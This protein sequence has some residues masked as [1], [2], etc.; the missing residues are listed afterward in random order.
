M[1]RSL[2]SLIFLSTPVFADV[3]KVVTDIAPVH[4]LVAMVMEGIETP[5]LL[6]P[7]GVSPH[8]YSMRPSEARSLAQADVVIWIGH[9]LMPSLEDPIES[10]AGEAQHLELMEAPGTK[11]LPFREEVFFEDAHHDEEAHH[12]DEH[13]GEDEHHEDHDDH[14][15][16]EDH[17]DHKE[18]DAHDDHDAHKDED[19]HA[20][21]HD[22]GHAHGADDP[23]VWLDPDNA[24]LWLTHIAE[25]LGTLDPENAAT[26]Q[27]NAVKGREQ[28]AATSLAAAARLEPVKNLQYLVLHDAFQYYESYF[29]LSAWGAVSEGDAATPGAARVG[30][31][32][33]A[34]KAGEV[35]CALSEV[36]ID[37]SLLE[38]VAE[39]VEVTYGVIDP[40]GAQ[41]T[42]GPSLYP[43]LLT[44]I[45]D[46]LVA[47]LNP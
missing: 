18:A 45:A 30:E 4:S 2:L 1:R 46:S 21:A 22:H 25:T 20:D 3:P 11:H 8:H 42:E 26:Y 43:A 39:G 14:A 10:L 9:A 41:L 32:R 19:H 13:H 15:D 35:T 7:G 33:A 12:D 23:H 44:G 17:E 34:F 38:T 47:C 24:S 31:L 36:Q 37:P 6:V 5:H 29:G 40:L 28:I 27:A 16:H